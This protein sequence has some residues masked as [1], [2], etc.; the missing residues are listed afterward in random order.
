MI[1]LYTTDT[2]KQPPD[3]KNPGF[4]AGINAVRIGTAEGWR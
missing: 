4:E 2:Q 1:Q 3:E